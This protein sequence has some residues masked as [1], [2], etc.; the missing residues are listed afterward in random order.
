MVV[1]VFPSLCFIRD[2]KAPKR[3]V[4]S[5][6][7]RGR[8]GDIRAGIPGQKLSPQRSVQRTIKLYAQPRTSTTRGGSEKL[9]AR[10]HRA[11]SSFPKKLACK[12]KN[13]VLE[14]L[15]NFSL[16]ELCPPRC[17]VERLQETLT[18]EP[19]EACPWI[20]RLLALLQTKPSRTLMSYVVINL[21]HAHPWMHRIA[22]RREA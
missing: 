17:S 13:H 10:K 3:K 16:K 6:M 9:Y 7:S 5:G 18:A 19:L 22:N 14:T 11:D 2:R 21:L 8:P 15:P 4:L 12:H 1:Y 20:D